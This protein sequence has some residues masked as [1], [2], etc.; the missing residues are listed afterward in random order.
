MSLDTLIHHEHLER[1]ILA[2]GMGSAVAIF[3]RDLRRSSEIARLAEEATPAILVD[4]IQR[5][6]GRQAI[7]FRSGGTIRFISIN[8]S[9]R[10]LSLDRAYVPIGVPD[11]TLV[12][13]I[14]AL[15]AS[16]EGV[17]TGY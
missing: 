13:I 10:G 8:Q 7:F 11:Q 5:S 4:K 1:A 2:A 14:P 6:N 3:T 15:A 12:D 9:A 17:L 16:P